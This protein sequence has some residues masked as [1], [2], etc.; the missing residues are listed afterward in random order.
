[1]NTQ[2][3]PPIPASGR[4][5]RALSRRCPPPSHARDAPPSRSPA[6]PAPLSAAATRS[7]RAGSSRS[8]EPEEPRELREPGPGAETAAAPRWEEA[9][10]FYDNLTSKKKPKSVK[11]GHGYGGGQGEGHRGRERLSSGGGPR[12]PLRKGTHFLSTRMRQA[13]GAGSGLFWELVSGGF[14]SPGLGFHARIPLPHAVIRAQLRAAASLSLRG[15]PGARG[16]HLLA[17]SATSTEAPRAQ[18]T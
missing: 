7:A 16:Q 4:P 17:K 14:F 6:P 3:P 8:M 11:A 12:V 13:L 5:A 9:K 18:V 2:R 10:T 15:Q 1:M